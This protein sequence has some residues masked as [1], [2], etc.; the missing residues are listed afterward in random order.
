MCHL[1]TSYGFTYRERHTVGTYLRVF[2]ALQLDNDIF[3]LA[4]E[5][6]MGKVLQDFSL[7]KR[8]RVSKKSKL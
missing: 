6:V 5:Y 1:F 8:K 7:N 3:L 2:Y 4:K